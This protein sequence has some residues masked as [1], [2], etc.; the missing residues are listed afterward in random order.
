M[1]ATLSAE[2]TIYEQLSDLHAGPRVF[3]TLAGM[4]NLTESWQLTRAEDIRHVLQHPELFS[5]RN[6]AGFSRLIGQEWDLIP[7]ENDPPEHGKYRAVM[8]GVF[9]PSRMAAL[10]RSKPGN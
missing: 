8:N 4:G 10:P 2:R 9:S 6:I 1:T 3:R 5:S 7:L